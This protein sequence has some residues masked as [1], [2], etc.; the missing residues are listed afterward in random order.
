MSTVRYML[1]TNIVSYLVKQRYPE[2]DDRLARL[3]DHDYCISVITRSELMFGLHRAE[4]A[5]RSRQVT[6]RFLDHVQTL[7]WTNTEADTHARL[8]AR[9]HV[10]GTPIGI[11]DE[12]IAAHAIALGATLVTN[13]VRH[14][15]RLQ[16]ELTIENWVAG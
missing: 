4:S 16:P 12:M 1:D 5:L 13:N 3:E 14:F 6:L 2:I 7:P 10:A 9:L 15:G 11:L 8:R